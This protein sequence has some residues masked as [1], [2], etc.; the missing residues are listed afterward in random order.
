MIYSQID[1]QFIP[2][3]PLSLGMECVYYSNDIEKTLAWFSNTLGWLTK[4]ELKDE[5]QAITYAV[6][7]TIPYQQFTSVNDVLPK[8]KIHI[9]PGEPRQ[10]IISI[11]PTTKLDK[12]VAHVNQNNNNEEITIQQAYDGNLYTKLTTI[13][14]SILTFYQEASY[15]EL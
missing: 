15:E 7:Y 12:L 4:I 8:I 9:L 1:T 10:E 14:G 2:D 6:A 5:T 3:G 13:D 11:I